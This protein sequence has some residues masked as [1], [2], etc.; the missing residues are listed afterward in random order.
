MSKSTALLFEEMPTEVVKLVD[1]MDAWLDLL[2]AGDLHGAASLLNNAPAL[3]DR[4]RQFSR[5]ADSLFA[6]LEVCIEPKRKPV[7]RLVE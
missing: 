4:I 2:R 1:L 3:V 5:D 7:L 6:E